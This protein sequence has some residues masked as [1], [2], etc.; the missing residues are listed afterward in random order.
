MNR[1]QFLKYSTG[2]GTMSLGLTGCRYWP[3]EGLFNP[4]LPDNL[5][6]ELK[7]HDVVQSAWQGI[8]VNQFW[9]CHTHLIGVGDSD[10]GIWVSPHMRSL[11]HPIQFTQFKFYLNGSCADADDAQEA[12]TI[13]ERFLSHLVRLHDDFPKG[14]KFMLIAFENY[15]DDEGKQRDDLSPFHTPNQYAAKVARQYPQRFEWIASVHPY[16]EDCLEMLQWCVDNGARAI[17]WLPGA[18]GIDPGSRKCDR[19]Y[20]AMARY[21]I[22]LLTH[23]GEEKAVSVSG[24]ED[25]NNP[26]LMRRALEHG[27]PVIFAH[28]AS[29]GESVDLDKGPNGPR[30]SN[31]DL[32]YR[33]LAEKNYHEQVY[34][35]VSA[36]TQVNRDKAVI[37]AIFTRTEWH[38]NLINGSDY[39]LPGVF[40]IISTQSFADWGYIE[41]SEADILAQIRR[42]NPLL[43]DFVLKR[44]IKVNANKLD[45]V[46]FESRRIFSV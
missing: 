10:S 29:L 4:C 36:I 25:L 16:R 46:V 30:V 39:P 27:V 31:L 28:C 26:L 35:D 8:D 17:K 37:E 44:A 3:A 43:F 1:R 33:L 34:G 22:L 38:A 24:G 12:K 6:L 42:F 41:Q 14:A 7:N 21:R 18:M 9:D 5:P 2:I 11:L 23:S 45:P 32:F 13:D 40:P 15:F 20:E 19:F